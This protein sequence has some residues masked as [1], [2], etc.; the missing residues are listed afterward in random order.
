MVL[1]KTIRMFDAQEKYPI[2]KI[3]RHRR[4]H[5][6]DRRRGHLLPGGN[7]AQLQMELAPTY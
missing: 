6:P 3:R 5:S 2:E 4:R 1:Q 7:R